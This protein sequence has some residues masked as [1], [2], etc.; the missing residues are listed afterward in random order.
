MKRQAFTLIEIIVVIV[1]IALLATVGAAS[2]NRVQKSARDAKRIGDMQELK[3]ALLVYKS[4]NGK[5]PDN[6][7]N[8]CL[9]WDAASADGNGDGNYFIDNLAKAKIMKS[10]PRDPLIDQT[11]DACEAHNGE[12]HDYYYYR[13][14]TTNAAWGCP[15]RVFIVIAADMETSD[16]PHPQS[17]GWNEC[18]GHNWYDHFD[19]V[20]GMYE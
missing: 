6:A 13:Y 20:I 7:D 12:G 3:K 11:T 5:F 14:N 16:A 4:I 17:P 2:Y 18:T 1:I 19:Y 15:K 8:D 9:G 10:V